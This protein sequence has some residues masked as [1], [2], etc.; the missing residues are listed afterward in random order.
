MVIP[1]LHVMPTHTRGEDGFVYGEE[2]ANKVFKHGDK[3]IMFTKSSFEEY[4]LDLFNAIANTIEEQFR[5]KYVLKT[6]LPSD[7]ADE[8]N[9]AFETQNEKVR[10][11]LDGLKNRTQDQLDQL[12]KSIMI[13]SEAVQ[14][15][16][17]KIQGVQ[18]TDTIKDVINEQL[19]T[20][21]NNYENVI[22]KLIED[23]AKEIEAGNK[24][25]DVMSIAMMKK[26][27][28]S[29]EEIMAMMK[30]GMSI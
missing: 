29:I 25:I 26:L 27:G 5:S 18:T 13:L 30:G 28:F 8:L 19:K 24:K 2:Y 6:E 23:K 4:P 12:Q 11:Q 9:N 21:Y 7:A 3:L 10:D 14:K 1:D 15:I 20:V 17:G 22:K 16:N